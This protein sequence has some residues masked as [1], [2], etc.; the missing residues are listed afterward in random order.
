MV[1][2]TRKKIRASIDDDEKT[3]ENVRNAEGKKSLAGKM[4]K[5]KNI[6]GLGLTGG[7]VPKT[8]L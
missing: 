5:K 2:I 6:S 4:K 7:L 1:V 3:E 8:F